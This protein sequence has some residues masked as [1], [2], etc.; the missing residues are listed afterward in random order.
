MVGGEVG[1]G[2]EEFEVRGVE[3]VDGE[4]GDGGVAEEVEEGG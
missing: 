4:G 2:V 1:E 3:Q